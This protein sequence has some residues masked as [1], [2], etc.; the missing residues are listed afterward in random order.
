[1]PPTQRTTVLWL[2]K[3]LSVG[4]AEKLLLSAAQ[5]IDSGRFHIEAA[6]LREDL[7]ALVPPLEAAGVPTHLL[8]CRHEFDLRWAWR[9][10]SLL[11]KRRFDVLHTHS[12]YAAGFARMVATTM[13]RSRRPRLVYTEHSVWDSHVRPT[14]VLNAAT[15]RLDSA[16]LAVSQAVWAS[17]PTRRRS[18]LELLIHGTDLAQTSPT[19]RGSI[20]SE[21]G[22]SAAEV[23]LVSVA[24]LRPAKDQQRLL[25]VMRRLLDQGHPVRLA[26]AG[27][28][29][30]EAP[31]R[32]QCRALDLDAHVHLLGHRDDVTA[33]LGDGDAF[34]FTSAWE[35]LPVAVMEAM[36]AGLPI[37]STNVGGIGEAVRHGQDGVLIDDPTVAGFADALL[38]VVLDAALRAR[39]GASARQRAQLFDIRRSTR[40]LEQIYAGE[41]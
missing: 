26:L 15:Y 14:R 32:A 34:V 7:D 35:G 39:M 20:R 21:L 22:V 3:G 29:P 5:V 36:A 19:P 13:T 23:L 1:M 18:H 17:V 24:N 31:L 4:G 2:I 16:Q 40:R 33:L 12:P 38:P 8:G 28:G 11:A 25:Q 6:Y 27:T 37:V 41:G 30:L 10:R 9:L